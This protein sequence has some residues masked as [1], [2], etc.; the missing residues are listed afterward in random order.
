MKRTTKHLR[1]LIAMVFS[2]MLFSNAWAVPAFPKAVTVKQSNGKELTYF[3]YGDEHASWA[4]TLDGYMIMPLANGDFTYAIA[5][6]QG[7]MVPSQILACNSDV[8]SAKEKKFVASLDKTIFY[9][10]AQTK[11]FESKRALRDSKNKTL[12]L[13]KF[14]TDK[15]KLL[16][17]LVNY[18]DVEFDSDNADRFKHQIQDSNYTQYGYTGSVRDY[19]ADQSF[20]EI[21]PQFVVYGPITLPRTRSYY[22]SNGNAKAWEMAR[23]AVK[24]IDTM[25]S[26]N[27]TEFD[28]DNDGYVDLV[29]VIYAGIGSNSTNQKDS[30]VWPHMFYF[31]GNTNIDGKGF[32]RYAC[33]SETKS[34]GWYGQSMDGIGAVCH[35]MG[36]AFGL[37][38][39]YATS[40]TDAITPGSWDVMDAGSYNNDSKTPPYYSM[41]ERDMLGWGNVEDLTNGQ[42]TLYPIADSNTAY[43]IH[44]NTD[45]YLMFEYRN[46]DKWD[47]YTPGIG[48][49]VWHADTSKFVNWENSNDLNNDPNDRGYF[50]ECAGSESNLESKSTPYPGS[51][52]KTDIDYF[53]LKNGNQVEG[54]INNI[55]YAADS[56][57]V[58]TFTKSYDEIDFDLSVSDITANTITVVGAFTS[59][60]VMTDKVLQYKKTSSNTYNT[61]DLTDNNVS[62]V[63]GNLQKNTTYNI[64]LG[65]TIEGKTYYS[66]VQTITT[67]CYDGAIST[68]SWTESFESGL[69]CWTVE[70]SSN[71]SWE[72]TKTAMGGYIS[73]KKGSYMAAMK[74]NQGYSTRSARLVSPMFDLSGYESAKINFSYAIYSGV[75]NPLTIYYRTSETGSW[76]KISS[77]SNTVSG[78]SVSWKSVSIDL[79][80]INGSYQLSFVGQDNQ[81]YGVCLDGITITGVKSS[82]LE[83]AE[84]GVNIAI[85]PNPAMGDATLTLNGITGNVTVTVTDAMGRQVM[86]TTTT[87]SQIVLPTSTFAS[88]IYYI[89]ATNGDSTQIKKFIKK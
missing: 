22:A 35:E 63:L 38:D 57:I 1:L 67:S 24:I 37:P 64:R 86:E 28:N 11:E 33:S 41:I 69:N 36:H 2:M 8:R 10:V 62:Y 23:D 25:Y 83:D 66:A 39:M 12:P 44:L 54:H 9:S 15:P 18:S 26:V 70:S 51:L 81:G 21:D 3:I 80:D 5:D 27:F 48:M 40:Y 4:K 58:F 17:V 61:V 87:D 65:V 89:K 72:K 85:M 6:E 47:A 29:H 78:S 59:D 43:K 46:H 19:F 52:N 73:P 14:T 82:S 76:T 71:A 50:I 60:K 55:H 34:T 7:N 79:P 84:N 13:K 30:Q 56:S 16:V 77:Y 45:E 32:Y 75:S 31:Q 20:G 49:I 74:F 88:G 53:S 68:L 42:K